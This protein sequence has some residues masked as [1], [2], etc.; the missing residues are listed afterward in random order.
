MWQ[1]PEAREFLDGDSRPRRSCQG[2]VR[3]PGLALRASCLQQGGTGR[4]RSWP[5]LRRL[6]ASLASVA[7]ARRVV[8]WEGG[9]GRA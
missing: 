5:R 7:G 3:A 4:R 1:G 9:V 6:P 8:M 2:A